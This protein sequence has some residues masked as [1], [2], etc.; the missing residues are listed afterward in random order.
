MGSAFQPRSFI[1]SVK[2]KRYR[3]PKLICVCTRT[4]TCHSLCR[5]SLKTLNAELLH[6]TQPCMSSRV[7][8]YAS[9]EGMWVL[10]DTCT[11]YP[12]TCVKTASC[13]SFTNMINVRILRSNVAVNFVWKMR[14]GKLYPPF[15]RRLETRFSGMIIP[16]ACAAVMGAGSGLFKLTLVMWMLK[17][18]CQN[19]FISSL[20]G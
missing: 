19:A 14:W 10:F 7:T 18:T 9:E 6:Q 15:C 2:W 11:S 4:K 1:K 3:S 12:S 17:N 16:V 5:L 8:C 20:C 13:S